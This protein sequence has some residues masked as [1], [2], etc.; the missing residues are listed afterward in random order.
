MTRDKAHPFQM[1]V[2]SDWLNKI[3]DW[4][5]TQADL[6]SRAEA[7]RRLVG[8]GL[9]FGIEVGDEISTPVGRATVKRIMSAIGQVVVETKNG[10]GHALHC[11]RSMP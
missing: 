8:M 10:D 2:S 4:R 11:P 9:S 6:P 7:I 5:R 3:D 1:R